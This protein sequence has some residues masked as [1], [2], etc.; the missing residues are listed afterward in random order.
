M[1]SQVKEKKI[2]Y[3]K[4]YPMIMYL[5]WSPTES[6]VHVILYGSSYA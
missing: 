2:V 3:N 4:Y 6:Q 1:P 5:K